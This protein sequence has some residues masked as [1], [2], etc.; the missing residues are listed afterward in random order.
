MLSG[1]GVVKKMDG[2][3]VKATMWLEGR[4]Q[5]ASQGTPRQEPL[6]SRLLA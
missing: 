4:S 6:W 2:I 5:L 3:T 1:T